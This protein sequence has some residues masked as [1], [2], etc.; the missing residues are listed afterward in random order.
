MQIS[1][2]ICPIQ[3]LA[4]VFSGIVNPLQILPL[5]FKG[6]GFMLINRSVLDLVKLVELSLEHHEITSRLRVQVHNIALELFQ[7]INNLQEVL[8]CKE[9]LEVFLTHSLD[10][11][12][13]RIEVSILI[14][15][16]LQISMRVVL[17]SIS[18]YNEYSTIIYQLI[19]VLTQIQLTHP[20]PQPLSQGHPI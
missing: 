17:E 6:V 11:L 1:Y 20:Q 18:Q 16:L 13:N 19:Y 10:D 9:E 2:C 14:E 5:N 8:M 12:L 4:K 7:C 3:L 15:E